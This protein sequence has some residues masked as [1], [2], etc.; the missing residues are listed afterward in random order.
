MCLL[1]QNH[2]NLWR[3]KLSIVRRH[4]QIRL[5][6]QHGNRTLTN[7]PLNL[8]REPF[9]LAVQAVNN[10]GSNPV[11]PLRNG[12]RVI[13]DQQA[14]HYTRRVIDSLFWARAASPYDAFTNW[15]M[16]YGR[17]RSIR[18]R[19]KGFRGSVDMVSEHWSIPVGKQIERYLIGSAT[20]FG[21]WS[22][23]E[24]CDI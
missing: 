21:S 14:V 19:T 3:Q 17:L 10:P 7:Y 23:A 4:F 15:F 5:Q 11:R 9:D 13:K 22:P 16:P 24:R 20:R 6:Q 18:W 12:D 2:N 1:H 8:F